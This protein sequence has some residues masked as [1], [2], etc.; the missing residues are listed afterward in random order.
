MSIEYVLN[1]EYAPKIESLIEHWMIYWTLIGLLNIEYTLILNVSLNIESLNVDYALNIIYCLFLNEKIFIESRNWIKICVLKWIDSEFLLHS[2]YE[3]MLACWSRDCE[4][5]PSF[6][7]LSKQ[8][9]DMQKR[10]RP[11]V[12]VDPSQDLILPPTTGQ[13]VENIM[14]Q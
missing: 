2:S 6:Q 13:G 1:I 14:F 11:Y 7:S 3:I 5:R 10:E 9:F 4:E 12:N 8:L